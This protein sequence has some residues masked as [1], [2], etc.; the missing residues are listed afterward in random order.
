MKQRNYSICHYRMLKEDFLWLKLNSKPKN[1]SN[2]PIYHIMFSKDLFARRATVWSIVNSSLLIVLYTFHDNATI[3]HTSQL[4]KTTFSRTKLVFI[5]LFSTWFPLISFECIEQIASGRLWASSIITTL[6][7]ISIPHA[8]RVDLC[9]N[10][11]YGKTT[12]CAAA[13]AARVA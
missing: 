3:V 13:I 1:I 2:H 10:V 8:S 12:R 7:R 6:S 5:L 4:T 11:W 9:I